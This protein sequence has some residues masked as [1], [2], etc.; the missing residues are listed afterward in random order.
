MSATKDLTKL[1]AD[2]YSLA[3]KTQNYHWNV[4]GAN[5][6][7]LHGLFEQ[8]Y[9]ELHA[10]VDVIAERIRA[11]GDY[12]PGGF[13]EFLSLTTIADAK[14]Q[15]KDKAMVGDLADGHEAIAGAAAKAAKSASGA[16]D[17]ATAGLFADR[18]AFHQKAAWMLRS[19]VA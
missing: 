10:A 3:L 19:V 9:T 5:F 7:G 14:G 8:Q 15:M 18:A 13:Q 16:G 2:T 6:V 11:L 4:E 12:A 1:L 17:E